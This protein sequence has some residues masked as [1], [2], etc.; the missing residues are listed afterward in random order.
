[1]KTLAEVRA[2]NMEPLCISPESPTLNPTENLISIVKSDVARR[3]A[4]YHVKNKVDLYLENN[5]PKAK[6]ILKKYF[7]KSCDK[8]KNDTEL[9]EN[10]VDSMPS[11]INAIYQSKGHQTTKY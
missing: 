4:T 3:I 2:R 5:R 7:E 9:L 8:M 10:L 6:K 11:R 1:M